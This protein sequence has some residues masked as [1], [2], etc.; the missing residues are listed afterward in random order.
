MAKKFIN[1]DWKTLRKL[2]SEQRDAYFYCWDKTDSAG[3]YEYDEDYMKVDL[4]FIIP[5]KDLKK[6]P[7]VIVMTDEK[8]L[9]SDYLIVNN[10]GLLKDLYNPHKP[11]FRAMEQHGIEFF[12]QL[13][14]KIETGGKD[15]KKIEAIKNYFKL[16]NKS[17]K[18]EGEGEEEGKGEGEEEIGGTGE[19]EIAPQM[20]KV[21]KTLYPN[22]SDDQTQ[23]FPA[24]LQIAY[25]IGKGQGFEKGDVIVKNKNDVL[26]IWQEIAEWT[27]SD[28][29][30]STRS[31]SDLNREWQ[32]ISQAFNN[33]NKNGSAV[34]LPGNQ[35]TGKNAGA[36]QLLE[37]IRAKS[38]AGGG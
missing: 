20:V 30:F 1:P 28:K 32:R 27:V 9:F 6:L 38:N 26:K 33:K 5:F 3:V 29:W 17:F 35:R 15:N 23:D 37:Q 7:G 13:D 36:H 10:S 14:L 22:Y 11:I 12:A 21:F 4:G 34:N 18:L 31:L 8:I 2:T 16:E 24:C 25:K 19:R